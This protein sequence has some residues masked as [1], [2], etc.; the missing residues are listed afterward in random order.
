MDDRTRTTTA[1]AE[2]RDVARLN[3]RALRK[4]VTPEALNA[5]VTRLRGAM[6]MARRGALQDLQLEVMR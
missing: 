5:E 1:R 4:P 6:D 3:L 2:L